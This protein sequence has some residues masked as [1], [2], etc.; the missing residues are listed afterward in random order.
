MS[1]RQSAQHASACC[2]GHCSHHLCCGCLQAQLQEFCR[3]Q[4]PECKTDHPLVLTSVR[5]PSPLLISLLRRLPVCCPSCY[6][7]V[8][9]ENLVTH[10]ESGCKEYLAITISSLVQLLTTPT[11]NLE[12]TVASSVVQR[13]MHETGNSVVVLASTRKGMNT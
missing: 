5:P 7:R 11:T 9:G 1:R 2:I 10:I 6:S 3:L 12:W 4:C 13:M 8:Q